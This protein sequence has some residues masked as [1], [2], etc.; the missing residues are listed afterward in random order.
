MWPQGMN[1]PFIPSEMCSQHTAQVGGSRFL[2]LGF[3]DA[4][5]P[6]GCI[7]C[8]LQCFSSIF[9]IGNLLTDSTYALFFLRFRSASYSDILRTISNISSLGLN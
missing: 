2:S 1:M 6:P 9:I 8:I 5:S 7:T 4:R 3:F